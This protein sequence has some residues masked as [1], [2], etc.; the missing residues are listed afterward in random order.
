MGEVGG[1]GVGMCT[2]HR[3]DVIKR[4]VVPALP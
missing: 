4:T 2:V 3:L 1:E